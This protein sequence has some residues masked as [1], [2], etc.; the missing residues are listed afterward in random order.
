V[1]SDAGFEAQTNADLIP[2][3]GSAGW[4]RLIT[5]Q[6]SLDLYRHYQQKIG[7]LDQKMEAFMSDLPDRIDISKCPM[8]TELGPDLSMPQQRE[9][10]RRATQPKHCTGATAPSAIITAA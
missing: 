8:V 4:R 6:H 9:Q 10:R 3:Q 7:E 5:L 2:G 1:L